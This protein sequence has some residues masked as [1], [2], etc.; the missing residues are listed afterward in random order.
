MPEDLSVPELLLV[1][2][3]VQLF[4]YGK[5]TQRLKRCNVALF[6]VDMILLK[7]R[8]TQRN[9]CREFTTIL[10][11]TLITIEAILNT[12]QAV[13]TMRM[14]TTGQAIDGINLRVCHIV[15]LVTL[16]LVV[17]T[18]YTILAYRCYFIW[19]RSFKAIALPTLMMLAELLQ[20]AQCFILFILVLFCTRQAPN[21]WDQLASNE[22]YETL[23]RK[24]NYDVA[25]ALAS[26]VA[27]TL[28]TVLIAGKIW[29]SSRELLILRQRKTRS[30][31][32]Y[33]RIVAIILESGMIVP[34]ITILL[35]V[36]TAQSNG[37]ALSIVT[38]LV[39]QVYALAPLLIMVRIGLGMSIETEK[40]AT[41]STGVLS[42]DLEFRAAVS[43]PTDIS[44][45]PEVHI[46]T[47]LNDPRGDERNC[48]A[49]PS[50]NEMRS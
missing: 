30:Q 20:I 50:I 2:A 10:L 35:V 46:T 21:A 43:D 29:W 44:R 42:Q 33:G 16:Q 38:T 36:Y 13:A 27:D 5:H 32:L 37:Q 3:C 18:S 49:K 22:G 25:A 17:A 14:A 15:N 24:K 8:K 26:M 6:S 28:L 1:T 47:S 11:F 40:L 48:G 23:E 41:L 7:Q 45:G 4:L 39:A 9:V 12:I 34:V 31:Q 19:N